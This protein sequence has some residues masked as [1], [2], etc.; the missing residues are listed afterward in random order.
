MTADQL[1]R[2]AEALE[3]FIAWVLDTEQATPDV[4]AFR[5]TTSV[6]RRSAKALRDATS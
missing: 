6:V 1:D 2:L 3:E 4:D 5:W